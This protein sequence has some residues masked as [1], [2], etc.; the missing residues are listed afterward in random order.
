MSKKLLFSTNAKDFEWE[1]IASA[2]GGGGGQHK[3]RTHTACRCKHPPSGAVA[4][5]T[6]YKSQSQNK[7][8]AFRR[9]CESKE[10][11]RWCRVEAS[12]ILGHPSAEEIVD[13][14]MSA[15]NIRLEIKDEDGKWKE[16]SLED[17]LATS[18]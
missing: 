12:R 6:E 2:G 4:I 11:Q 9:C 1:F 7:Q 5:S 16:I 3:N 13:D 18:S 14:L 10:F 17:F 15:S 8:A